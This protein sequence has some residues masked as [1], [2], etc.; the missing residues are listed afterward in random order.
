MTAAHRVGERLV[1][2]RRDHHQAS[3]R[4]LLV[5]VT[6]LSVLIMVALQKRS[7]QNAGK[8][9]GGAAPLRVASGTAAELAENETAVHSPRI[10]SHKDK[11]SRG[12]SGEM[13]FGQATDGQKR[14]KMVETGLR[15]SFQPSVMERLVGVSSD[16]VV[17][18]VVCVST[19]CI[20]AAVKLANELYDA[21]KKNV[22]ARIEL[23][24]RSKDLH[25][26]DVSAVRYFVGSVKEPVV[27]A[28]LAVTEAALRA[29]ERD[30]KF[31]I[32]IDAA[33]W[34]VA[35]YTDWDL[36]SVNWRS[37]VS[38]G[39][40]WWT[41][42]QD[43]AD[44]WLSDVSLLLLAPSAI[45][46]LWV[47]HLAEILRSE[48]PN[49]TEISDFTRRELLH[50]LTASVAV[51]E[52]W[53]R[54]DASRN[55]LDVQAIDSE[56]LSTTR[57]MLRPEKCAFAYGQS[58]SND[59]PVGRF[60]ADPASAQLQ[61]PE[62]WRW[63]TDAMRIDD[64][65]RE[66][67]TRKPPVVVVSGA[68]TRYAEGPPARLTQFPHG[69]LSAEEHDSVVFALACDKQRWAT[70]HDYGFEF[71][72]TNAIGPAL[73]AS[74]LR[75]WEFAKA[76]ALVAAAHAPGTRAKAVS[77][78][79]DVWL[80]WLDHDVWINPLRRSETIRPYIEDVPPNA[81]LVLSNFRS[82]NTG[83]VLIRLDRA[84]R[85]IL[86]DWL[87]A[88]VLGVV[89]CQP[90]DQAAL[91]Y[92]LLKRLANQDLVSNASDPF[93][94]TCRRPACGGTPTK[95]FGMCNPHFHE[96]INAALAS[97]LGPKICAPTGT[98]RARTPP[99]AD[100]VD[101]GLANHIIN[102]LGFHVALPT[103]YRPRL[104]CF[105]AQFFGHCQFRPGAN[106][107]SV[108]PDEDPSWLFAHKSIDLFFANSS[109][110]YGVGACSQ[111]KLVRSRRRRR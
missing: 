96:A 1:T 11:S 59:G 89:G 76:F 84:G 36:F 60:F 99:C 48:R 19:G 78:K 77:S 9:R 37:G 58:A 22:R 97:R 46:K 100:A 98:R 54:L 41:E 15:S 94:Y 4:S 90:Y 65:Q 52:A 106:F 75:H 83:V 85:A 44:W 80:V 30:A 101:R 13:L 53:W 5:L 88:V 111:A 14:S 23:W 43:D 27:D 8:M 103:K 67:S 28:S 20:P 55:G 12:S 40:A 34:A 82:L 69:R 50:R 109:T 26:V 102:P 79:K 72:V 92:V 29:A 105:Q 110:G 68:D 47:A 62:T 56:T 51:R 21:P 64:P 31:V 57:L 7:Q 38:L 18:A 25:H 108:L 87:V 45:A 104:Q 3:V 33:T 16:E 63:L 86:L 71:F 91:Q 73:R 39:Q 17:A 107:P 61:L 35:N 42:T 95:P 10:N 2:R 66:P 24:V 93:G 70:R 32:G 81:S 6:V 74:G 49:F